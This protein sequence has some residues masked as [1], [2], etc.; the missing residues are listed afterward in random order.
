M[1]DLSP[2]SA[3]NVAM[4]RNP[5]TGEL[6]A[7]YP[8]QTQSE[9]E[10]LLDVNAAAFRL[11]RATPMR[12]RVSAYRRLAATLRERSDSFAA[13]ITAEMGK[14]LAAARG[15]VEKCAATLEWIADN[16][17][18]ILADEPVKVDGDDDVHVSFLPIGTVLA[19]MPWNFPL[20]Q[21]IRASGPIMLSGNGFMLKHAP[22]VMGSAYAL[23]DAYEAAGFPKGL[24]TNLIADN[25]TVARTIED[26]RI[27]AVTLTGSMRAGSAVAATAGKALK[28]SLLELGGSDAFIV[29][30][31]ANIDLAVKAAVEARFQNAGQ[32]CLAAKRFILEEPIAE[33]FTRKFVA[34]V[35]QLKVGD[36]LDSAINVGP[37]ARADLR[38]ELDGQVQRTLA[39]GAT[40]LLG[41]KKIDGPGNFYA[42]TVLA[43][44]KPGM[45]AFDEETFGPVA[46]ITVAANAEEAIV[47]ANTSDYGLG[48]SLWTQDIT[49][50]QRIARR[51]ETGGVF[52]N[53]F[54]ATNARI[55]VGG[56]KKS[57]YGRELSHFGLRE[58]TNAQAVW[59]KNVD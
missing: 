36:P 39:A 41:G 37:M 40:L 7:T 31:D 38:D 33:Q 51:L 46:A 11:W 13:L 8:F 49:R 16:G 58:F 3:L 52:I 9:V 57:G 27:A 23:Q 50:A 42:P 35:E 21:V 56:V 59:A 34:A 10:Q 24:F 19:V 22:N 30:A 6:I 25:E 1:S 44:V 20:W 45:A 2:I 32:V 12:E 48:G 29:L 4:S 28:K 5:A 18:A 54:P 43:D 55:P 53:G 17:P 14:T 26:P 47:L 15:E